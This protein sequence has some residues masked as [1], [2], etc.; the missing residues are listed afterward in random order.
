MF[1]AIH[2]GFPDQLPQPLTQKF[3]L[4]VQFGDEFLDPQVF[5]T[6]KLV[7]GNWTGPS[8]PPRQ[9]AASGQPLL[10]CAAVPLS[11]AANC[12]PGGGVPKCGPDRSLG[13]R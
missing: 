8:L 11:R 10:L 6:G 2:V 13:A 12:G 7:P 3:E 9:I 4:G 5:R 1:R